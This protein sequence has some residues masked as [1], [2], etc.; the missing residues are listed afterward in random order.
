MLVFQT[1]NKYDFGSISESKPNFF[2]S[3]K[4]LG[5]FFSH[6]YNVIDYIT[7]NVFFIF[8]TYL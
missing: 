4:L 7:Y 8:V 5:L 2:F 1:N 3:C 6:D